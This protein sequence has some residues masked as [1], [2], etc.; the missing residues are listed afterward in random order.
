M[1]DQMARPMTVNQI[2]VHGGTNI[3]R[4][5]LDPIFQPLVSDKY[6]AP[7]TVGEVMSKLGMVSSKLSN[8]RMYGPATRNY[9]VS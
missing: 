7:Q 9:S 6:G 5:F 1:A 8:L 4:G 3:R 2:N